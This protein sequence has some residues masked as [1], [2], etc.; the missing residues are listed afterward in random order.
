MP[1]TLKK[2]TKKG[3]ASASSLE[4]SAHFFEK[5]TA[6]SFISFQLSAM[7]YSGLGDEVKDEM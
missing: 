6:L 4:A 1:K 5:L 2:S 7:G 3:C